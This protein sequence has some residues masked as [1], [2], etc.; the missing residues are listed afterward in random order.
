MSRQTGDQPTPRRIPT[1]DGI[2][3]LAVLVVFSAHAG[4]PVVVNGSTGVTVFFFLSGFLI[5]TLL[6]IE[7]TKQGRVAILGFYI[8][9]AL[10]I[11]PALY[12]AIGL[13]VLAVSTGVVSGHVTAGGVA[14]Q[15]LHFSNY[16]IV[17]FDR[18][19]LSPTTLALWSV[20]VEEH[21]YLL[22][23]VLFVVVIG[24]SRAIQ[25]AVILSLCGAVLAWR[26][27]LYSRSHGDF[28]RIYLATDSRFDSILFGCALALA[29]NPH[30][31]AVHG[32]RWVWTR[33][34][35][36]GAAVAFWLLQRQDGKASLT[37]SYSAQGICL[38]LLFIV[39]IRF[40]DSLASKLLDSKWLVRI[41][42][43]SYSIYLLHQ[44]C[45]ELVARL[46]LGV[47]PSAAMSL[48]VTM[49]FAYFM[50]RWVELPALK[51]RARWSAPMSS[52]AGVRQ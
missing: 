24:R 46:E 13:G 20:S 9:R 51:W 26:F 40:S 7:H 50:Y 22:F 21:F 30:V 23:P 48:S 17:I 28:D 33:V 32:S 43:L 31:D 11:L 44:L 49:V 39:L 6:R 29:Y 10:R 19:G 16:W 38:A 45:I 4:L 8:R 5:T 2:R 41:G 14:S 27:I 15:I 18:D 12:V 52:P 3:A 47:W 34:V 36:P 37:W 35:G 1:L 42:V 25:A